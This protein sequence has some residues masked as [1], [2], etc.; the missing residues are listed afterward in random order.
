ME[1]KDLID[2]ITAEVMNRLNEKMNQQE[3]DKEGASAKEV[4]KPLYPQ[5]N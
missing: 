1:N 2:K 5:L 4:A 3:S